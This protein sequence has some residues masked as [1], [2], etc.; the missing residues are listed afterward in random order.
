MLWDIFGRFDFEV[1]GFVAKLTAV[2]ATGTES[3]KAS[4]L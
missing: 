3:E 1:V 2:G 4:V